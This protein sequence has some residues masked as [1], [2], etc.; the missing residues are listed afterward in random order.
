MHTPIFRDILTFSTILRNVIF[1]LPTIGTPSIKRPS[2]R[3]IVIYDAA[4]LCVQMSSVSL[5]ISSLIRH[6][7]RISGSYTHGPTH[8]RLQSLSAPSILLNGSWGQICT[9]NGNAVQSAK[10]EKHQ[11]DNPEGIRHLASHKP[12]E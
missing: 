12:H 9:Q 2:F 1:C 4:G 6:P 8:H 7:A 10:L 11:S 5:M 3:R